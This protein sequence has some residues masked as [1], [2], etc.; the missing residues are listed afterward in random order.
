MIRRLLL[1]VGLWVLVVVSSL[2]N[3]VDFSL[4]SLSNFKRYS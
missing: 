4:S 1:R 2:G 3:F